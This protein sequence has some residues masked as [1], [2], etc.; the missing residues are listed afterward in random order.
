MTDRAG[1]SLDR[2]GPTL[3][4]LADATRRTLLRAVADGGPTTATQLADDLPITRQAVAK[5]LAVLEA[6]GLVRSSRVGRE[7]RFSACPEALLD[8]GRSLV[9]AG[10]A[11][12][13]R[14]DRLTA[15][16]RERAAGAGSP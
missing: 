7:T 12:D 5:Q 11:W 15:R 13:R 6:A 1:R 10:E 3:E 16:A 14:I 2:A 4:A 8:V 9:S